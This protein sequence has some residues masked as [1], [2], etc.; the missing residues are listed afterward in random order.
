MCSSALPSPTGQ[1]T[2]TAPTLAASASS[3]SAGATTITGFEIST[4]G[5]ASTVAVSTS[6]SVRASSVRASSVPSTPVPSTGAGAA[7]IATG[8]ASHSRSAA[9]SAASSTGSRTASAS[10]A[11]SAAPTS[12]AMAGVSVNA[13]GV[14]GALFAAVALF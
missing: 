11:A 13:V 1:A 9:A 14:V 8:S 4:E 2:Y 3:Y 6:E 7:T 5:G 10:A 12:G